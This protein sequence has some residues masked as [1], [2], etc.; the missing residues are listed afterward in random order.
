MQMVQ[1]LTRYLSSFDGILQPTEISLALQNWPSDHQCLCG[2]HEYM[3][4]TKYRHIFQ[5]I[6]DGLKKLIGRSLLLPE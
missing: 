4:H 5:E 6:F 2:V 3:H 1:L